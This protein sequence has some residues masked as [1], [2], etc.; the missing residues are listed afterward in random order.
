MMGEFNRQDTRS[1]ANVCPIAFFDPAVK[2]NSFESSILDAAL[3]RNRLSAANEKEGGRE[4]EKSVHSRSTCVA[5]ITVS[6]TCAKERASGALLVRCR[7]F[8]SLSL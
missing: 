7:A 5:Q 2:R 8:R 3:G 6:A 1:P 4:T